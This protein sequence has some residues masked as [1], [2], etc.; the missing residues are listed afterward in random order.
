M[1]FVRDNASGE[2]WFIE[3][4]TRLQVEHP[5][6]EMVTG[7]DLVA[8]QLRIAAGEPLS[9]RQGDIAFHGHAIECRI[10]AEDPA[11]GFMPQPGVIAHLELPAAPDLRIDTDAASG[12]VV[13]PFYDPLI[14]KVIARGATRDEAIARMRAALAAFE[15]GGLPTNLGLHRAIL[16]DPAFASGR[17]NTR[18]LETVP[19]LARA[20][21]ARDAAGAAMVATTP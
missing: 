20:T 12:T 2:C 3:M 15:I 19:A 17:F 1:E 14:A 5:V 7:L 18:F 16:D 13:T 9:L 8:L 4:N 11:Q 21:T 10:N 6:T